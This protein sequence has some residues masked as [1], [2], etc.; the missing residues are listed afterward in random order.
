MTPGQAQ[1]E[2]PLLIT[3]CDEVLL[4]MVSH[5]RDWLGAHR[6]VDFTIG[7]GDFSRSMRRREGAEPL[8]QEE[9]WALLGDFFPAEMGRSPAPPRRCGRWRKRPTSWC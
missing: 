5:F 7:A 2:R 6:G 4:H 1:G 3:D 8:T 9:M